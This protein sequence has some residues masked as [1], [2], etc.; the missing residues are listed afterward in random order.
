ML[1]S[2]GVLLLNGVQLLPIARETRWSNTTIEQRVMT[3]LNMLGEVRRFSG[4]HA[5]QDIEGFVLS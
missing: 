1:I 5:R 3:F 2:G 4:E